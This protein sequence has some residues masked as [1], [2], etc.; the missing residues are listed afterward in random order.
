MHFKGFFKK[1]VF[2]KWNQCSWILAFARMMGRGGIKS[3]GFFHRSEHP[4]IVMPDPDRASR[5][6]NTASFVGDIFPNK[7]ALSQCRY[8]SV[9]GRSMI[10]ML[11]VLAIMGVLSI[12][13]V[14]G[15]RW[16]LVKYRANETMNELNMRALSLSH[17]LIGGNYSREELNALCEK[18][19]TDGFSEETGLGYRVNAYLGCPGLDYF[20]IYV[21]GVGSK[22]C[23]QLMKD[24]LTPLCI[25][26]GERGSGTDW[27]ACL[28]DESQ[29][30]SDEEVDMAFIYN[31]D[32]VNGERSCPARSEFNPGDYR[33]H[34]GGGTYVDKGACECPAGY[35]WNDDTNACFE[36][37]CDPGFFES[38]SGA[39]V[40][41]DEDSKLQINDNTA[42]RNT[43]LKCGNRQLNSYGGVLK[44]VKNCGE[45]EFMS[46]S[47]TCYPCDS[48]DRPAPVSNDECNKCGT[49]RT[50]IDGWFCIKNT[51]CYGLGKDQPGAYFLA[52]STTG[53]ART[54]TAC[55][56]SR[57]QVFIDKNGTDSVAL[58][59]ACQQNGVQTRQ[60]IGSYCTKIV[61]S[62]NEFKGTDGGCYA[63]SE[64]TSVAVG[65]DKELTDMCIACGNREVTNDGYCQIKECDGVRLDNGACYPC[66]Y[67]GWGNHITVKSEAE[68]ASCEACGRV[69]AGSYCINPD[70]CD[71]RYF[72]DAGDYCRPCSSKVGYY[73]GSDP[74]LVQRCLD[75]SFPKQVIDGYCIP[76]EVC[77]PGETFLTDLD[78]NRIGCANCNITEGVK[79]PYALGKDQCDAC[80]TVD[81]FWVGDYC[82]RCDSAETP[83]VTTDE[84]KARCLSCGAIRQVKDGKCAL[85]TS[86]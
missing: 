75:C 21:E 56:D 27:E 37:L 73:I 38:L 53:S 72:I 64:I 11:G 23:R 74:Y 22:E 36:S 46:R 3:G 12:A 63:C 30:G 26:A 35:Q 58:C 33:C 24:Y 71:E 62:E 45:D 34:C 48:D 50:N 80:T 77:A 55:S 84:E 81:R 66:D 17:Q 6:N 19:L 86:V 57:N 8:D 18:D 10:E 49:Q 40:P 9:L 54:C 85:V 67:S 4:T 65:T 1:G 59:N 43:C 2:L 79:V 76:Q 39:C 31:N 7:R 29:C 41:C 82:Y 13:A 32:L 44:C 5:A 61:C 16:A 47:G 69:V 20:E 42:A 28:I 52:A 78:F 68:K 70:G 83:E 15:Y 60:V 25:V 51:Y 14:G